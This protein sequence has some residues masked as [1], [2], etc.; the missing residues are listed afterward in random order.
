M[1]DLYLITPELEPGELLARVR[2][3]LAGTPPGRV[4][5]Q[6]RAGHLDAAGRRALGHELR[7]LTR[8]CGT[9]LIVNA[10]VELARDLGAEGVQLKERGPTV[11]ETRARLGRGP[12]IGASRH[13]RAGVQRAAA[14]GADFATLSPVFAV[15]DKGDPLGWEGFAAIARTAALPLFALGGVRA[16]QAAQLCAEGARGI[17]VIREVFDAA[18]P[19]AATAALLAAIDRG[20]GLRDGR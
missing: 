7:A 5:L 12:W 10:E 20:R 6:L 8:A 16:E 19:A 11:A 13:D 18:E 17:A 14:E 15:P 9:A 2:S 4:A 1:F 3:A